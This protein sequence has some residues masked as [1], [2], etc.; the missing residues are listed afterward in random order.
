RGKDKLTLVF[1]KMLKFDLSAAKSPLP[2][3][4]ASI[5]S[6][7]GDQSTS[8]TFSFIGK[9]DL[10]TFRE[11]NNFVLDIMTLDGRPNPVDLIPR[12][13]PP[14][15]LRPA[16]DERAPAPIGDLQP[17][18]TVPAPAATQPAAQ[19]PAGAPRAAAPAPP[20]RPAVAA[21]PPAAARPAAL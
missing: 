4:V 7:T 11:D 13:G 9:I 14:R 20:P 18:Q 17:P 16:P 5:D 19:V 8:V 15:A 2:P 21:A 12:A 1:D 6:E 3:M 10:R